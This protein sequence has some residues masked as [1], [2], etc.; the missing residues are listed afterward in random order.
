MATRLFADEALRVLWLTRRRQELALS[1]EGVWL[2]TGRHKA[3]LGWAELEQVQLSYVALPGRPLAWVDFFAP[4]AVHRVGVFPRRPATT[5]MAACAA[6]VRD[7]GVATAPLEGSEGFALVR[8]PS[9][10]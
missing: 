9:E 3:E 4:D 10:L 6:A 7:A 8:P 5:W 1:E 2:R